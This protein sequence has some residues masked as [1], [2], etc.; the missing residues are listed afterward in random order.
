MIIPQLRK[1]VNSYEQEIKEILSKDRP[2]CPICCCE[3]H[4]HSK[5]QRNFLF[6]EQLIILIII[7][8]RCIECRSVHAVIPDYVAPYRKEPLEVIRENSQENISVQEAADNI[9]CDERTIQRWRQRYKKIKI[10]VINA[11]QSAFVRMTGKTSKLFDGSTLEAAYKSLRI[12]L[13]ES[14]L[15]SQIN[16]FLA[17]DNAKIWL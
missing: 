5:Y 15:W 6:D 7:R 17:A 11:L 16:I 13:N 14:C 9:C 2:S 3:M 4:I 8:L 12:S 1:N 10:N